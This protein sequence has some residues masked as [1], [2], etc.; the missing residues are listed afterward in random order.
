MSRKKAPKEHVK[1][2]Y[3]FCDVMFLKREGKHF[4]SGKCRVA[5]WNLLHPRVA[6]K[7]H[8]AVNQSA[9]DLGLEATLL[10]TVGMVGDKPFHGAIHGEVVINSVLI[11]SAGSALNRTIEEIAQKS[12]RGNQ[13]FHFTDIRGIGKRA[14]LLRRVLELMMKCNPTT[15]EINEYAGSTRASSDVSELRRQGFDSVCVSCGRTENGLKVSR[16]ELTPEGREKAVEFFM[17][18]QS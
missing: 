5:E 15:M 17:G 12:K 10:P 2:E 1:C 9:L 6:K 14:A 7:E 16:F 18:M 3:R 4:C 8:D 11:N 13:S